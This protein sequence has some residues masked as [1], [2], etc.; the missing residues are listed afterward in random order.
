[1]NSVFSYL[2]KSFRTSWFTAH[3]FCETVT[4]FFVCSVR[5]VTLTEH[6]MNNWGRDYLTSDRV[7]PPYSRMFLDVPIMYEQ[8]CCTNKV[9]VCSGFALISIPTCQC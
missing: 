1:M 3:V 5:V 6:T 8:S 9:S 7:F 4:A 2:E